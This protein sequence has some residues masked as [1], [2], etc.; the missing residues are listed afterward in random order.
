MP[1]TLI[2]LK[3][4][5]VNFDGNQVLSSV[6]LTLRRGQI[7]TLIGP[8]G[9]GKSTLVKVVLNLLAASSGIV[10]Q[11]KHLK[12][13]YVPQKLSINSTFPLTVKRFLKLAHKGSRANL[14]QVIAQ[15]HIDQLQDRQVRQLSGGE[16]QR[17]LVARAMLG[18]P[19]LLVLDEP[20]QGMDVNAQAE[21]YEL[22]TH[23]TTQL[24]CGVLLVSHDLHL[25]MAGSHQV[26]C[27]NH[28]I[29]CSGEPTSVANHPEFFRLFGQ[30][31]RDQLAVYTHDHQC[32]SE[33]HEHLKVVEH[34]K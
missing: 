3:Q 2:E 12:I 29:C 34:D 23:V 21:L 10:K 31:E 27:L 14:L 19:E 28:H 5:C 22:I 33:E 30:Q 18:Q 9:A 7:T 25:V 24:N 6:D 8:N 20:A 16:L 13:G 17:V 32:N 11:Q 1:D 26:I 4:V 15:T